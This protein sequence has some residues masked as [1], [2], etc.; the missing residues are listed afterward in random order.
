MLG[1]AKVVATLAVKDIEASKKFYEEKLGLE[2]EREMEGWTQYTCGDGTLLAIYPSSFAGTNEGTAAT[3]GV[4][5][6][7]AEVKSLRDKGVK[8]E[9]YELPG[10]KTVN[11]IADGGEEGKIAW[12]KD[13]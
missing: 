8:F 4:D 1:K 7:E 3:F 6:V 5:D 13:P 11:G 9:D 12:F 10:L 2:S